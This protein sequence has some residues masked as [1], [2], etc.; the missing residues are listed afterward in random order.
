MFW[1][2]FAAA[3]GGKLIRDQGVYI[4]E[5]IKQQFDGYAMVV[6]SE[7]IRVVVRLDRQRLFQMGQPVYAIGRFVEIGQFPR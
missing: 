6:V 5:T 2:W 4:P 1:D 3:S 7:I